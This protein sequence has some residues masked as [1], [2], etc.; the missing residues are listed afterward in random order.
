MAQKASHRLFHAF[1][2]PPILVSGSHWLIMML[3]TVPI[4]H[5][6]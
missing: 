2:S 1:D 3:T 4:A 6:D 5:V